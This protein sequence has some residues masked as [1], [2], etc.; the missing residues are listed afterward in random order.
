[1][2]TYKQ[3]YENMTSGGTGSVFDSGGNINAGS[4]GNQF[5]SQS[6]SA[7]APGDARMPYYMGMQRRSGMNKD[8]LR[9]RKGKHKSSRNVKR[10]QKQR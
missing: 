5:P 4:H 2:D 7:Y 3:F 9:K 10:K 6:D 1:M 8:K